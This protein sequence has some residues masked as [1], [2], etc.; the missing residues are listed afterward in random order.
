MKK[1]LAYLY[2]IV[3]YLIFF[4][5]FLWAIGF[6]AGVVVPKTIDSGTAGAFWP[7][8]AINAGLLGLFGLQHSGMARSGFKRVWTKIVPETIERSTYV[9]FSSLALILLLWQWQPMPELIWS[10]EAEAG[11]IALWALQAFGWLTVLYTTFLIS[12]AHLFGLKQVHQYWRDEEP[13]DPEFQTP[14]PYKYTRH[15]MMIG[16]FF[17][18]WAT[19]E[20]SVGHLVF[21]LLTTGYTLVALQL[22]ERDLIKVFGEKYRAYRRRVPMLIPRLGRSTP[23]EQQHGDERAAGR[24]TAQ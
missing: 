21:A 14:G 19:P 4:G 2:G 18:F 11:R 10:V 9:L 16:F 1:V 22:E 23:M 12:H 7:S 24:R 5:S 6:I 3:C 8:L 15:P 17:A 20:M 13:E